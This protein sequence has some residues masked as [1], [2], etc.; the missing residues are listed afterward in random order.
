MISSDLIIQN[1]SIFEKAD[2]RLRLQNFGCSS[3]L[4]LFFYFF[5]TQHPYFSKYFASHYF[6]FGVDVYVKTVFLIVTV[7]YVCALFWLSFFDELN[8]Q[9]K[10]RIFFT[11]FKKSLTFQELSKLEKTAFLSI[12]LKGFYAPLMVAWFIG[13]TA[14]VLHHLNYCYNNSS[15][16]FSDFKGIY[17]S[18]LFW[19]LFKLILFFDVIFFTAGYLIELP[20]LNNEIKSVEPTFLGWFVALVCYPP[21]NNVTNVFFPWQSSDLPIF[22]NSFFFYLASF[23]VLVCMGIYSWA[24]W[25]LGLKASNLTYRGVVT[26]GAYALCRHPAYFFKNFAWW[27]GAVPAILSGF[28]RDFSDGF[29]VLFCLAG[30]SSLYYFRA[31]TE[32]RHL[33]SVDSDYQRYIEK[34]P[35]RFIP[36]VI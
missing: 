7:L 20:R 22:E 15:L 30:W 12:L 35:F 13:H 34:V 31:V 28:N 9:A 33:L 6:F 2:F 16:I 8:Q 24:S 23:E 36:F 10:T 26:T 19:L 5:Y 27:I 14:D 18:H 29:F 32:E 17:K 21:F 11:A 25:S 1:S 4:V 3:G